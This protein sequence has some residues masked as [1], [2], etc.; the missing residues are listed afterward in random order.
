VK[1][2]TLV[3]SASLAAN[4]ALLAG[5]ALRPASAPAP[6][7][8]GATVT[9]AADSRAGFD[10]S[11]ARDSA[12]RAALASGNARELEAAGV[13]PALAREFALGRALARLV[14]KARAERAA[15]ADA[16][17]W[18]NPAAGHPAR[19][20]HAVLRRELSDAFAAAFGDDGGLLGGGM[21]AA[22]LAFLPPEKREALRR[23]N[24]DYEEMMA[25]FSAGGVQLPS[26]RERL[27][28]LREERER[29]IAALLSPEER[30][31]YELR[32]SPTAAMVRARYGDGIESEEDFRKIYALQKAFD[33][34][35]PAE[36]LRNRSNPEGMRAYA[37]AQ[38]QLQDDIRTAV[39]D[40]AYAALRRASDTDLRTIDSLVS[41]LNLPPAT[42]D[43]V[44]AAREM[45]A[46]ES[47]R[48]SADAALN[49]TQRRAQI[50]E[51]GTRARA[52][53]QQALGAEGAE[54]YAQRS[55]WLSM[56]QGGVAY[57]TTPPANSPVGMLGGSQSVYPVLPASGGAPGAA[58][59]MVFTG[60]TTTDA[61]AVPH[62]R[63]NVQVMTFS[64]TTTEPGRP[65]G[66]GGATTPA[67]SATR[68]IIVT[69]PAAT[70][71]PN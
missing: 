24:L 48:L 32:T 43:R 49:P 30:L 2:A 27:K 18:R 12:L 4:A 71:P 10:A 28:L 14:A 26:D 62:L 25:K 64:T 16:R 57:A 8:S 29:D 3:L 37:D 41:R 15:P 23:I 19:E 35:F 22:T 42:T 67:S 1:T 36:T 34:K 20:Q 65:A 68:T 51:L 70:T 31:A 55:P 47:Q 46:A 69:P 38:R 59:Q 45:F 50:Q 58:R 11:A 7:S 56:L 39:G 60:A 33:E 54:A 44:A 21:P 40:P 13:D 52:E 61:A 5:L 63:E 53:V 17:W 6:A 66:E 9:P